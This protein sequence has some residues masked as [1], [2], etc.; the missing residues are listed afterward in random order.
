LLGALLGPSRS[1]S[2]E[3]RIADAVEFEQTLGR[4]F[5]D[6]E[7]GIPALAEPRGMRTVV[8]HCHLGLAKLYRRAGKCQQAQENLTTATAMYREWAWRTG[9]SRAAAEMGQLG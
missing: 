3:A 5:Y 9:C 8:A 1:N 2:L 7:Y 6:V 4:A